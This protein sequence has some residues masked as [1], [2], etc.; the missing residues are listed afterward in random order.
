MPGL[1]TALKAAIAVAAVVGVVGDEASGEVPA[2]RGNDKVCEAIKKSWWPD[3]LAQQANV[4]KLDTECSTYSRD[5]L[6]CNSAAHRA[7]YSGHVSTET[8]NAACTMQGHHDETCISNL[9]NSY[10]NGLCTLQGTG[11]QCSWLTAEQVN[12][13]NKF[14]GY[15]EYAGHGCYRNPCNEP[16]AGKQPQ[17]QCAGRAN[18]ILSCTWCSHIGGGMGCQA[19]TP[20][21]TAECATV[22]PSSIMPKSGIWR[23]TN[24]HACQCSD[25][26]GACNN[27][28]VNRIGGAYEKAYRKNGAPS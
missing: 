24:K 1:F 21:T 2:L 17:S 16:G 15:K 23:L 7:K 10:N 12:E 18:G 14:L 4:T 11:G 26:Y 13:A 6:A 27:A 22:I 8:L 19:T 25:K 28:L 9:C 20:T 5:T 3:R